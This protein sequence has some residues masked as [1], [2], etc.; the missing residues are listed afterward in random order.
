[1]Y[2]ES[3]YINFQT[4]NELDLKILNSKPDNVMLKFRPE[5]WNEWD[6]EKN[7]ELGLD[8]YKITK[9]SGI[10]LWWKCLKCKSSY[11]QSP[12]GRRKNYNCY[13]CSG[14]KV[15]STNSLMSLKPSI[16]SQWHP[17]KN[18][19][20][21]PHSVTCNSFKKIWWLG[22]C[23]HEWEVS[24]VSRNNGNGC[25]YCSNQ[26][27]LKGYND[28]LTTN[29]ELASLLADPEDGYKYTQGSSKKVDW[30]CP[31]CGEIIKNKLIHSIRDRGLNCTRCSD[32]LS[33]GERFLYN[34]LK[35][36]N[37]NFNKEKSFKWSNGKRYDFY[38]PS[39]NVII[40]V[41]GAQHY[42]CSFEQLGGRTLEEE[43][44]ND[45]LKEQLAKE[46]GIE[47]YIVIDAR[48]TSLNMLK[49]EILKNN[50]LSFDLLI[51]WNNIYLKSFKSMTIKTCDLWK[52]DTT[53]V[54]E[55]S[56]ALNISKTSVR[57]YLSKGFEIGYISKF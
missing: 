31:D 52:D 15:N 44:E 6:F 41:H 45:R 28:I 11:F 4:S 16:A 40:E 17:T 57:R 23:G 37:V 47:H 50:I 21:T 12:N 39:L 22:E 27:V 14:Y 33:F 18:G 1:M 54:S 55:I 36:L 29:P 13:F 24:V 38:L 42:N 10:K 19:E 53:N 30:K 43:Q 8:I 7:D 49:N 3:K 56:K 51:D 26:R 46:N 5:L 25:P 20:L 48:D 35:T 2:K 32:G 34:L 9:A